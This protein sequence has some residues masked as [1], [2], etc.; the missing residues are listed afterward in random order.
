M[1]DC[2]LSL[3]SSYNKKLVSSEAEVASSLG[4][5]VL[6]YIRCS[7]TMFNN[8]NVMNPRNVRKIGLLTLIHVFRFVLHATKNLEVAVHQ[9]KKSSLYFIEFVTQISSET[10]QFLK[11]TSV[12][13]VLFTYKKTIFTIDESFTFCAL[14]P[15]VH[16]FNRLELIQE[17]YKTY[18]RLQLSDV[19]LAKPRVEAFSNAL[20]VLLRSTRKRKQIKILRT[21]LN[22]LLNH[23]DL[24][25]AGDVH[26]KTM[27]DIRNIEGEQANV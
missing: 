26:T 18:T 20:A 3:T 5:L 22:T 10:N 8:V 25:D 6:E 11:L 21:L 14:A 4:G 16:Q 19:V 13:A 1:N 2:S 15:E 17:L 12:D 7:E 24:N 23:T 27:A 9:S